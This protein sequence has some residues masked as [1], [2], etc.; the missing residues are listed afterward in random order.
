MKVNYL[1]DDQALTPIRGIPGRQVD[2]TSKVMNRRDMRMG[3][4]HV[5]MSKDDLTNNIAAG[6]VSS[7]SLKFNPVTE[8]PV[9]IMAPDGRS[10]QI[11][12]VQT[13]V[14]SMGGDNEDYKNDR[15]PT[16]AVLGRGAAIPAAQEQERSI[17]GASVRSTTLQS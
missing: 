12:K 15:S 5:L 6:Y 9:L 17:A 1:S 2:S 13:D 14:E 10:G 4:K 11:I 8:T 16:A 7:T 3:Y